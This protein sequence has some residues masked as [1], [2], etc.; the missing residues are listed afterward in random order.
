MNSWK[1]QLM[2]KKSEY[3]AEILLQKNSH[4]IKKII[5]SFRLTLMSTVDIYLGYFTVTVTALS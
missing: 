5:N 2:E 3:C 1:Q 4:K